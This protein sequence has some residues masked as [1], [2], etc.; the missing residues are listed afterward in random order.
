MDQVAECFL[1]HKQ[2][3]GCWP[4]HASVTSVSWRWAE[5]LSGENQDL[6][7][8]GAEFLRTGAALSSAGSSSGSRDG[9]DRNK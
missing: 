2:I 8:N 1:F 5:L 7:K 3:Y 6:L 4:N 9:F